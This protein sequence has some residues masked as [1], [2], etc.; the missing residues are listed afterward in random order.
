MDGFSRT[1]THRFG[2]ELYIGLLIILLCLLI[3][4]RVQAQDKGRVAVLPFM[5]QSLEPLDD[6]KVGLQQMLASLMAEKGYRVISPNTVNEHPSASSASLET[7]DIIALG[8]E[9]EADWIIRGSLTQV[10]EKISIDLNITDVSAANAPFSIFMIEDDIDRLD[11]ALESSAAGIDNRI[12]G[13]M[14]IATIQVKGN[15]RVESDAVLAI[16]WSKKGDTLNQDQLDRDLHAVYG[17]GYF[18]DVNI[19]AEDGPDGK[20]ITFNVTEKP[21]I[22]MISFVGNKKLKADKLSEELGIKKYSIYNQSDVKQSVNRLKEFYRKK[23]YYNAKITD[24]IEELPNNEVSLIYV[25]DEGGKAYI[26]KIEFIGNKVFS[27]KALKKIMLTNEKGFFSLFTDAGILDSN[28]LEYDIMQITS[29]YNNNGYIAARVGE[30]EIKYNEEKMELIVTISI[31]EGDQYK[32]NNVR[33]EGDLIKPESELL[34]YVK[35][36]KEEVFNR[37]VMY[38]DIQK[39][40]DV[41]TNEGYAYTDI[42]TPK[43]QDDENHLIDITYKIDK[44]KRVRI[45]RINIS[46]NSITRDK[47][48]RRELKIVEGDFFSGTNL[49]KSTENLTRLDYFKDIEANT[50]NGSQDD[51]MVVDINIEEQPTGTFSVGAGYSSY[52]KVIM[53]LQISQKNLFGRGQVVNLQASLGSRTT[54][55]DLTF[56]EPWLFNKNIS[57]SI[58]LYNWETEYDEFTRDSKGGALGFG[59]PLGIDDYTRGLIRYSYDKARIKYVSSNAALVMQNMIGVN[60]TSGVTVGIGRDSTDQPWNTTKGSINSLSAEY[61]GGILG[62]DSSY[63]KYTGLSAWYF[64]VWRGTVLMTKTSAGYVVQRAGGILPVYEK[65]R[66]GGI[67]SVRG[68]EWGDIVPVDPDTGGDLG[69]DMM[70][71]WNLEYR[72]PLHQKEGVWGFVFFDAGNAFKKEDGWKS[73]ARRSVGFGIRWRSPMGPLRM[74]YGIKLDKKPGDSTGEFEFN[75]G[76]SF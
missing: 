11:D 14:R 27:N 67:D 12:S 69:G 15:R 64:P 63:T 36:N 24:K 76:G 16:I 10:G 71:L 13:V 25:M 18:S 53:M 54:E 41:Y 26:D 66:V 55:F 33:I 19:E 5:V 46:G 49:N 35:L 4:V 44:K 43:K 34:D 40:K 42:T 56:M 23:G 68:Y 52:E 60:V 39:L 38:N 50:R 57:S 17:M 61:T 75:V 21:V 31:I 20:I 1:L 74:E 62:G 72:F 7:R 45:E 8:T 2:K 73:G 51:L 48:I 58:N 47:V 30:P 65:F 28:K 70:W 9:L 22:V 59:F 29:F 37:E 32:V 3:P 6:F